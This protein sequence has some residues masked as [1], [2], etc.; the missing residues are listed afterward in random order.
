MYTNGIFLYILGIF[1]YIFG[2]CMCTLRISM[3]I[4]GISNSLAANPPSFQGLTIRNTIWKDPC[5]IR[6]CGSHH[7]CHWGDWLP[8]LA[9]ALLRSR[10]RHM[11]SQVPNGAQLI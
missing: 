11:Q 10:P 5:T 4:L 6:L 8:D 2:I 9:C 1:M 3:Y 7:N